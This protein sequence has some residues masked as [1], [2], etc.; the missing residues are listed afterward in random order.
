MTV[1]GVGRELDAAAVDVVVDGVV[2]EVGD[3]P[4][5]QARVAG[6]VRRSSRGVEG[7]AAWSAAAAAVARDRGEVDGLMAVEAALA[8]RE[9]EQRFDQALLLLADGEQLLAGVPVGLDACVRDR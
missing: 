6:R 1:A 9:R 5:D 8:A 4:L 2:D 3:E 7:E